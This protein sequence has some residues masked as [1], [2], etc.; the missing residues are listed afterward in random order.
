M[1]HEHFYSQNLEPNALFW[2]FPPLFTLLLGVLAYLPS[3]LLA[4]FIKTV[5]FICP[6]AYLCPVE[7]NKN[8]KLHMDLKQLETFPDWLLLH[9]TYG[10]GLHS[11]PSKD[12]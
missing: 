2:P 6:S 5:N 9:Y 8:K 4:C 7:K 10:H 11:A 1:H 3:C 12:Q